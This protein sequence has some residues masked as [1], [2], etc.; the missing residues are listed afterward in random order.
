M[1]VKTLGSSVFITLPETGIFRSHCIKVGIFAMA[2]SAFIDDRLRI[3]YPS[4]LA[5]AQNHRIAIGTADGAAEG[6][7][8]ANVFFIGIQVDTVGGTKY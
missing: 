1:I 7:S 5:C 6:W 2:L 4:R 3:F 8:G